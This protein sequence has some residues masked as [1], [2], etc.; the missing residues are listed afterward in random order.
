MAL[1]GN[2]D[3]YRYFLEGERE[4]Y[5]RHELLWV[6]RNTDTTILDGYVVHVE[7]MIVED[8]LS[9]EEWEPSD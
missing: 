8:P 4:S 1:Q 5:F 2:P 7:K 9:G 3:N 6:P